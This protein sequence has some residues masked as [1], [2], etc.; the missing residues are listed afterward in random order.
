MKTVLLCGGRG[1]RIR[2]VADNIPKPMI[3][4]GGLPI[5]WHIMKQYSHWGHNQFVLCLGYQGGVIK[6][7]FLNYEMHTQDLTITLGSKAP[8]VY[9]SNVPEA[10]W[11]V[12]LA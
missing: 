6:D 10:N 12:T 9:H 11:K 2:D 4:I 5:I 3:P 8:V 1:T 7:F